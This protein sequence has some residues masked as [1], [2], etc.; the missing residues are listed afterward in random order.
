[1]TQ[2]SSRIRQR[3]DTLQN[4]SSNNIVLLDGEL[5]IVD[6]G[7]QTRFK[8]GN[9]I[10]AFNQL[11]FVDENQLSTKALYANEIQA[12]AISQGTQ[13]HSTPF[14]LAAGYR[15][16]AN[17]NYSQAL[18][19]KSQTSVGHDFSF[20]WNGDDQTFS[21]LGDDY[22]TSHGKGTF[23]INPLSGLSGFY[24]GEQSLAQ[25][26]DGLS[27]S[28]DKKIFIDN[29]IS[30]ISG[31]S[32]L[33]IV[34]LSSNEYAN[35]L[36]SNAL[37]SN[38]IYIVEDAFT[39]AYGEQI[40]NVGAPID[41]SDATTK[42]YVDSSISNSLSDFYK[43]FE[44]SSAIEI[45]NAL[46][47]YGDKITDVSNHINQKVF[48]AD[49]IS[50]ISSYSD[51]SIIKLSSDEYVNLL[52]SNALISN[53][54]YIVEKDY[55]DAYGQQ[56]KNVA[57]AVDLSDAVNLGQLSNAINGIVVPTDLS[58]LTNSPGYLTKTSADVDFQPKG[59]YLVSSDALLLNPS[60]DQTIT[61]GQTGRAQIIFHYN[62]GYV[63]ISGQDNGIFFNAGTYNNFGGGAYISIDDLTSFI[64]VASLSCIKVGTPQ[65]GILSTLADALSVKLEQ[66]DVNI[67]YH[68]NV[69]WLSSRQ[70]VT[71]VD[72]AD[73]IKDG[74]LST[75]ELCSNQLIFNFNTDA[76]SNPISIDLSN[77]ID[78][79]QYW[80]K[81]ETSSAVEISKA[82]NQKSMVTFVD[83]ED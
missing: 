74:M 60:R 7:A 76:G 59:N 65:I 64:R 14:G 71:S 80:K 5:A 49:N 15:L 43:K 70:H 63:E 41:L 36:T 46:S 39:N 19:F 45:S 35:L 48:I 51:L 31:Y 24:I 72:C 68:D 66:S 13:A 8:I 27:N 83:W 75:I 42:E 69:I 61:L 73:F 6:C 28:I 32:D 78:E 54:I 40:K 33:S 37:L 9:G 21:Y 53:A 20:A 25:T 23:S 50:S 26:I 58:D 22:Y 77:F 44:T 81:N 11:A 30:G 34:R 62:D 4:W 10:S 18:G 52:I 1:M 38:A 67:A 55:I 29:R 79:T 2:I 12:H 56:I 17:G 82:L 3:K 16:S 47:T 57:S